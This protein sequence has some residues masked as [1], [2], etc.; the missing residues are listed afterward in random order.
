MILIEVGELIVE[1]HWRADVFGKGELDA[2]L[3][4]I[5]HESASFVCHVHILLTVPLCI[6]RALGLEGRLD[7]FGWDHLGAVT[8]VCERSS[9]PA[10]GIVDLDL[11]NL[12]TQSG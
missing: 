6:Q 10:V 3:A 8:R 4:G 12:E 5:V 11:L 9:R 2:A 1:E 7:E